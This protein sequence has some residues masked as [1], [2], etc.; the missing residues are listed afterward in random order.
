M[1]IGLI[2][3]I[4]N[5]VPVVLP[6]VS[7]TKKTYIPLPVISAPL[8]YQL[9]LRVAPERLASEKMIVIPVVL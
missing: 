8:I 2:V 3:S 9:P 1:M 6:K 5:V 7:L 4:V